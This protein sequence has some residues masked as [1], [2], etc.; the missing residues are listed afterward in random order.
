MRFAPVPFLQPRSNRIYFYLTE[1][2]EFD[3]N[4]SK[5][6]LK[7]PFQLA[8]PLAIT[9]EWPVVYGS[10]LRNCA[11]TPSS[12]KIKQ[13]CTYTVHSYLCFNYLQVDVQD[14]EHFNMGNVFLSTI[15][16]FSI[17]LRGSQTKCRTIKLE[18]PVL[19]RR[20][21]FFNFAVQNLLSRGS[22]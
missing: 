21:F 15:V 1:S 20:F 10:K 16:E 7:F 2:R 18:M 17:S 5:T 9:L 12:C 3:A 13:K 22:T 4:S 6:S 8:W 11:N 19:D 14:A